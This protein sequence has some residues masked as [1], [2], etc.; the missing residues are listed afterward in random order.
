MKIVSKVVC[1]FV[2]V[3]TIQHFDIAIIGAGPAGCSAALTLQK[4][5]AKIALFEKSE[6]PR[7]KI[8]GDGV[9]DRSINTLRAINPHYVDEFLSMQKCETIEST[10]IFYKKASYLIDFKSFGYACKRIEFDNFLFSLVQRDCKNVSVFQNTEICL[11]RRDNN[12]FV[13]G[14]RGGKLF[15]AKMVLICTGAS[16]SLARVLTGT[17]FERDTMGV[18]IRA[19]YQG[20]KDLQPGTIELHYKKEYFPGYLWIFPLADGTA[21][22]GFGWHLGGN[23]TEKIQEVFLNWIHEDENLRRR[24]ANAQQISLLQGGLVPYNTNTFDCYGDNYCICGDSANLI[25]PISGGGI[26]SAM[27]SGHFAAQVAEKAIANDD[28]RKDVTKEYAEKLRQRVEKE[29]RIRYSIQQKI[30]KHTWLLDVL[31]FVGKQSAILNRIK[32]WYLE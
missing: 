18:A 7:Q 6:F 19:Y 9:C 30:T 13:L 2:A 12:G 26:G 20:I 4:S 3:E 21:N 10:R 22:V 8:C 23:S 29:M 16:S 14:D 15:F 31:A 27:V 24:F 32:K 17:S 11:L 1:I 28:Y 25:D 5:N